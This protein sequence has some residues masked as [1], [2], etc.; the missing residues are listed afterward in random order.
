MSVRV[1]DIQDEYSTSNWNVNSDYSVTISNLPTH[2]DGTPRIIDIE[3]GNNVVGE[4]YSNILDDNNLVLPALVYDAKGAY[5]QVNTW[6]SK[7]FQLASWQT[8]SAWIS[9][10]FK[11]DGTTKQYNVRASCP[12]GSASLVITGVLTDVSD[13][14]TQ[15]FTV[16]RGTP[17]S[18]ETVTLTQGKVYTVKMSHNGSSWV[19]LSNITFTNI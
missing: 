12:S 3:F 8:S 19:N 2:A 6:D 17:S 18:S 11:Y 9:T 1:Y 4:D 10:C 13:G 7:A 15:T 5:I 16:S 14:S